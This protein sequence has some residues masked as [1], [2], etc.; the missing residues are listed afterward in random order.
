MKFSEIFSGQRI[1]R[2][3]LNWLQ[4]SKSSAI[5]ERI[6]DT[7]DD[8]IVEGYLNNFNVVGKDLEP[9]L[10]DFFHVA[11]NTGVGYK[12][13]QRI[14]VDNM[15]VPYDAANLTHTTDDGSGFPV[16]TPRS[17]GSFDIPLTGG[18]INYLWIAYVQTTDDSV[19]T[20]HK[21]TNTKQF[22]KRTDGYK[23]LVTLTALNPDPGLYLP[24]AQVNLQGGNTAV[25]ANI[26]ITNRQH[27]RTTVRR[28]GIQTNNV[29]LTDRPAVYATGNLNLSLDDHIKA[30]GTGPV[31]PI[32]P[33]GL[34]A[35]DLGLSE[36]QLVRSHRR[37]EHQNGI[38]GTI[39]NDPTTSA[40]Y[41]QVIDREPASDSVVVKPLLNDEIAVVN[42]VAFSNADFPVEVEIFFDGDVTG[43]YN[44]FFDGVTGT[45]GKTT[46]PV[47]SDNTKLWLAT[48]SW[49]AITEDLT[50]NPATD[51]R[52]FN[53]TYKLAR[54][55]NS[56]RPAPAERGH[57]GYNMDADK[58]EYYNGTAWIQLP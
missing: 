43:T 41:V 3:V 35:D 58:L 28:V 10:T 25:A 5:E 4:T 52:R 9:T 36:D 55:R 17:T 6:V 44:I 38:A 15:F 32:N 34:S 23:I 40:L 12:V 29:G 22:Y 14:H 49:D 37:V 54:W 50:P 53:T 20:L 51:R 31:S 45:V 13:G 18:A 7:F 1:I 27:F 19:F 16:P 26:S 2:Q 8:G 39:V 46:A 24:L 56:A 42:G 57:F 47:T 48:V 33:H 11:V 21:L 30:V